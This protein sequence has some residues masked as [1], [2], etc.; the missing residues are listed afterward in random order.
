[1][2]K[3]IYWSSRNVPVILVR[4]QWNLNYLDEFSKNTQISNFLKIPPVGADLFHAD[5]RRYMTKLTVTFRNFANA[6][7]CRLMSALLYIF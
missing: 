6:I 5:R 7:T 3:N 4:L 1:M 2:I